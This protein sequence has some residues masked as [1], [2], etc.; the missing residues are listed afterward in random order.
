MKFEWGYLFGMA[1]QTVPQPRK[2]ARDLFAFENAPRAVLWQALALVMVASA[3][4]KVLGGILFPADPAL[5]GP[6]LSDPIL[7]GFTEASVAVLTAFAIYWVGR[8]VG[9]TGSFGGAIITVTWLQFVLLIVELGVLFLSTFAP[10]LAVVLWGLGIIMSFWILT[11]FIAELHHFNNTGM[12]FVAIL[13][14]LFSV[15]VVMSV[16]LALIGLGTLPKSGAS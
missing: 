14:T 13:L 9:G 15:I 16:L 3:W 4:L 12:V 6:L 1:L 8:A 11:H 7:M 2:V 5:V 10:G